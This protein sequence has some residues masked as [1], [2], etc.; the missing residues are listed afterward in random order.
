MQDKPVEL[1]FCPN[2]GTKTSTDQNFCRACALGHKKAQKEQNHFLCFF[3]A[4]DPAA[5]AVELGAFFHDQRGGGDLAFYVGGAAQDQFL[6]R[7][8]VAFDGSVY[9]GDRN[10]DD[11]FGDFGAGADDQGAIW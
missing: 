2:C 7:E 9:L 8:N 5:A 3:V 11:G 10:F 1:C 4:L 6:A